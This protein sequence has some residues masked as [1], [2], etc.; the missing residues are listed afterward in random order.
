MRSFL[1]ILVIA[2]FA[3]WGQLSLAEDAK[4]PGAHDVNEL[5]GTI[6]VA[7]ADTNDSNGLTGGD[8]FNAEFESILSEYV[9]EKG[10]V[11]Y[12]KLRRFRLKLKAILAQLAILGREEYESWGR[13]EK[14]AFWVNTWNVKMLAIIIENYPIDSSRMHR[15]WWPPSSIRHIPPKFEV[16][17]VKWNSY[18]FIVMDE[19]FNL[20]SIENRFFRK[21]FADP[22]VFF[23]LC[24]A[25]L[26]S[27]LLRNKPYYGKDLGEQL[28]EQVRR[29]LCSK[30]GLQVDTKTDKVT[31]SVLFEQRLPWYG[32]E[33]AAKYGIDRK[34]KSHPAENRAVLN[35]IT[36]YVSQSTVSYLE[37]GNYTIKYKRYDWRLNGR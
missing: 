32:G 18:K 15:L 35:F 24:S 5:I 7:G 11:D 25:N 30:S 3:V 34:F 28:D 33:F 37:T 21:E 31:L 23:A 8:K 19:E 14:I 10:M 4:R 2:V 1:F 36:H 6:H 27:P 20:Y 16:G 13:D 9:D 17:T 26:D 22:R 12:A 29:F